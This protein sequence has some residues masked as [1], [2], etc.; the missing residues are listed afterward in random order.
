MYVFDII[1]KNRFR[2]TDFASV[3]D[4]FLIAHIQIRP[5]ICYEICSVVSC[6][7]GGGGGRRG[8]WGG[9]AP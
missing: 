8:V 9:R 4:F 3:S 6:G 1:D 5:D 7:D 2:K